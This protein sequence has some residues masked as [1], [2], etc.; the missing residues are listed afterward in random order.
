MDAGCDTGSIV[1]ELSRREVRDRLTRVVRKILRNGRD[2]EDVVQDAIERGLRASR[3]FRAEASPITW[4]H[5]IAVNE[6]LGQLRRDS[7]AARRAQEQDPSAC[8][9]PR[10]NAERMLEDR[11]QCHRLQAAVATL[12]ARYR[13]VVRL[14]VFDELSD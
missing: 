3:T 10:P 9:D 13:T 1:V 5:R 7:R 8:A 12:P 11:E 6:A 14:R 2:P 4:L